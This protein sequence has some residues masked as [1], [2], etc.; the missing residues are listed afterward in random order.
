MIYKYTYELKHVLNG[1]LKLSRKNEIVEGR[2]PEEC[3][4]RIQSLLEEAHGKDNFRVIAI[5]EW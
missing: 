1:K 2:T 4:N 5:K 3:K